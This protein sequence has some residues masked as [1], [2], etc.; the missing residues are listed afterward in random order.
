MKG[1][2]FPA[3]VTEIA[4]SLAQCRIGKMSE[5]TDARRKDTKRRILIPA[6]AGGACVFALCAHAAPPRVACGS[7]DIS[8]LQAQSDTA[9]DGASTYM[10]GNNMIGSHALLIVPSDNVESGI[11]SFMFGKNVTDC[12]PD[13]RKENRD[14]AQ[15]MLPFDPG[16]N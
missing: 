3:V 7:D 11:L 2:L 12:Q 9:P 1:N 8:S 5:A 14:I 15:N 10:K 16:Q 13:L 6:L 4:T